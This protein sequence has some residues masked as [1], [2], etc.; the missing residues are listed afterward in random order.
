MYGGLRGVAEWRGVAGWAKVVVSG[1]DGIET[2]T[3]G[4]VACLEICVAHL[5]SESICD[6]CVASYC[7]VSLSSSPSLECVCRILYILV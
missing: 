3:V 5:A 6:T 1:R 2:P 4:G 7:D